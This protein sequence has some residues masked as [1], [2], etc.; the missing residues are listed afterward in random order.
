MIATWPTMR[1]SEPGLSVWLQSL[2][3]VGRVAE[4]LSLGRPTTPCPFRKITS[5]E[6]RSRRTR[7]LTIRPAQH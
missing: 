6:L 1:C 4:L 5:S 3:P 7:S 2:R